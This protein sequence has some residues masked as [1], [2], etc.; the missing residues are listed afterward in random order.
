[1][2]QV[3]P[4]K[5]HLRHVVSMSQVVPHT[6]HLRHFVSMPQVVPMKSLV[7]RR[8]YAASGTDE[9]TFEACCQSASNVARKTEGG[10]T[11]IYVVDFFHCVLFGGVI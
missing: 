9:V 1:M 3:V 4:N 8:E 10:S 5:Y 2:H 11:N 6:Y 7:A